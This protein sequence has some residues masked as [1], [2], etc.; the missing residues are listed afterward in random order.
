MNETAWLRLSYWVAALA[1]FLIAV[2]ILFPDMVGLDKY[3]YHM[4][5][6][7]AVAI[8]W[9]ILSIYADR[10]PMERRW[11]LLPTMI[12]VALLGMLTLHAFIINR[13]PI[14]SFLPEIIGSITIFTLLLISYLKTIQFTIQH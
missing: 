9:G 3:E 7:S 4:G 5:L 2:L 14:E 13:I 12:V 8:S 1:D 6:M 10:N 11:V